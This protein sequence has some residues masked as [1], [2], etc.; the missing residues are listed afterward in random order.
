M[1]IGADQNIRSFKQQ[2][3]NNKSLKFL[4]NSREKHRSVIIATE[5]CNTRIFQVWYVLRMHFMQFNEF[6][7]ITISQSVELLRAMTHPL[8]IALLNFIMEH[9]PVKVYDIHSQ[10]EL[11]KS[12][13]SQ[14]LRILRESGIV[15]TS[16]KGK[17][18]YYSIDSDKIRRTA[19][20]ILNFDKLT[21]E[22]RRRKSKSS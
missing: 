19:S 3:R 21:L 15:T 16:R 7:K 1:Q 2:K 9:G 5:K 17:Y 6:E 20:A 4:N 12:I 10:L 13:T 8:R 22:S 18:I 14:H 11:D